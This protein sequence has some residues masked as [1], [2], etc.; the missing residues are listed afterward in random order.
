MDVPTKARNLSDR[1][2]R[3][4]ER[5]LPAFQGSHGLERLFLLLLQEGEEMTDEFDGTLCAVCYEFLEFNDVK[6][7]NGHDRLFS[8]SFRPRKA[9]CKYWEPSPDYD[10]CKGEDSK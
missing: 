6:N 10:P 7:C 9:R 4:A 5:I 1:T 3:F 2:K 8:K